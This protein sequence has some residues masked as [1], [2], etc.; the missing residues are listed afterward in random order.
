MLHF[1]TWLAW[2]IDLVNKGLQ[3]SESSKT[4]K[5]ASAFIIA[6]TGSDKKPYQFPKELRMQILEV[7]S[8]HKRPVS[9]SGVY[10]RLE[11]ASVGD[12]SVQFR[13]WNLFTL[14]LDASTLFALFAVLSISIYVLVQS[15][16]PRLRAVSVSIPATSFLHLLFK[17][18]KWQEQDTIEQDSHSLPETPGIPDSLSEWAE[19]ASATLSWSCLQSFQSHYRY[20]INTWVPK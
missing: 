11:D 2:S 9:L 4:Y 1:L 20:I 8:D 15:F 6:G 14:K 3:V 16:K 17:L 10:R 13:E 5:D 19:W 18:N 7:N 12:Y